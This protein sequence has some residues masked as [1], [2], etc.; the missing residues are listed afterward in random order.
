MV[1][2]SIIIAALVLGIIVSIILY[3]E[4]E[5]KNRIYID[6]KTKERYRILNKVEILINNKSIT[7]ILYQKE[8]TE[9][10]KYFV[11]ESEE[12]FTKYM[13]LSNYEEYARDIK[14]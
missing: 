10:S 7:G 2:V 11:M 14:A 1:I 8:I 4:K 13:K 9:C 3:L 12:F 5:Y 6:V